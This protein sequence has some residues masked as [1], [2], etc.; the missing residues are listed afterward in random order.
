MNKIRP[1]AGL[2]TDLLTQ[3]L[4]L[5]EVNLNIHSKFKLELISNTRR[6]VSQEQVK[7]GTG[8]ISVTTLTT[9]EQLHHQP[10]L[11]LHHK[12]GIIRHNV[13]MVALA[14]SLNLFLH[15]EEK[16]WIQGHPGSINCGL[17]SQAQTESLC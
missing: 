11:I 3:E 14:H 8:F 17:S 12:G 1:T 10:Q 7:L 9:T 16:C 6:Q 13:W 5:W 2:H 4:V 15:T